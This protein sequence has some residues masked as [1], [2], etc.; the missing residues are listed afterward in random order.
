[1]LWVELSTRL[2]LASNAQKLSLD[3]SRGESEGVICRLARLRLVR[4][5]KTW[6]EYTQIFRAALSGKLVL[7]ELLKTLRL[8][9]KL[10]IRDFEFVYNIYSIYILWYDKNNNLVSESTSSNRSLPLPSHYCS[11]EFPSTPRS[12]PVLWTKYSFRAIS[13]VWTEHFLS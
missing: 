11:D 4:H 2:Q 12:I 1:M 10:S 7:R 6:V 3:T 9:I 8:F 13:A 5:H